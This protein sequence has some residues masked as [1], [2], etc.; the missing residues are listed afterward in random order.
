MEKIDGTRFPQFE[1]E[2]FYGIKRAF[3]EMTSLVSIM[4]D[5]MV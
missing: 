4:T 3:E 2:S 5:R 1:N